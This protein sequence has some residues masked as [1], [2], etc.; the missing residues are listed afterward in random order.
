MPK[1]KKKKK[2]T[3]FVDIIWKQRCFVKLHD[4]HKERQ[5]K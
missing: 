3:E 4:G 1:N 2:Q 5:C